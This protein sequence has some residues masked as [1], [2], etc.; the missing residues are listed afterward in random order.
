MSQGWSTLIYYIILQPK[1]YFV[2]NITYLTLPFPS[3][4]VV[5][6]DCK[7]VSQ[8][9]KENLNLNFDLISTRFTAPISCRDI[10]SEIL[11]RPK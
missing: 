8:A 10:N 1:S 5:Q 3:V 9:M 2:E 11:F 4:S 6:I 7:S